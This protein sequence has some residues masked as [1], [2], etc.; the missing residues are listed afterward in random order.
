MIIFFYPKIRRTKCLK[1]VITTTDT[2]KENNCS[3]DKQKYTKI[4]QK[5]RNSN[6]YEICGFKVK[7]KV[8]GTP[9]GKFS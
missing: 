4:N 2:R 3:N 6:S 7:N 9:T 5:F 8:R 1:Y